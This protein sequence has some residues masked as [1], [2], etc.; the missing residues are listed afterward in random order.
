M[1]GA[2]FNGAD[3]WA[4]LFRANLTSVDL[5]QANR[6]FS[7]FT[8]IGCQY[9]THPRMAERNNSPRSRRIWGRLQGAPTGAYREY[10]SVAATR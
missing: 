2:N 1:S 8:K 3:L 7:D 10:V 6:R 5:G 4:F 9:T